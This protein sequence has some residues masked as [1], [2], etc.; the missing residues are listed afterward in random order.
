[1]EGEKGECVVAVGSHCDVERFGKR[2]G[3][4]GDVGRRAAD[5]GDR[6]GV[7]LDVNGNVVCHAFVDILHE[8]SVVPFP[9]ILV[10]DAQ[11]ALARGRI[12]RNGKP[13]AY[14]HDT[15][16][17]IEVIVFGPVFAIAQ[18]IDRFF[19][20]CG[21]AGPVGIDY[22]VVIAQVLILSVVR[23]CGRTVCREVQSEFMACG[24]FYFVGQETVDVVGCR[25]P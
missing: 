16:E 15:A 13:V 5:V 7:G 9:G 23:L 21:F 1:M 2:V 24:H 19:V 25:C 22:G 8:G 14:F 11:S 3:V 20:E 17:I 12:G 10:D 6:R 18:A 4:D